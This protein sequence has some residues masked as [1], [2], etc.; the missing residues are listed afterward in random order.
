MARGRKFTEA[1]KLQVVQEYE[2]GTAL[3]ALAK[4]H[5]LHPNQILQWRRKVKNG[6]LVDLAPQLRDKDKEI[7]KLRELVGKLALEIEFLKKN[8]PSKRTRRSESSSIISGPRVVPF[9]KGA[10]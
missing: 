1:F 5:E 10:S 7:Q 6:E 4:R 9:E 8:L 2:S 3:T